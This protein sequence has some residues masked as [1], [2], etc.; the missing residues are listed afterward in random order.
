MQIFEYEGKRIT[1]DFGD[2][3]EMVSATE[4][5]KAFEEKRLRDFA[6]LKQTKEFIKELEYSMNTAKGENPRLWK[7]ATRSVRGGNNPNLRGIWY[8]KRLALKLAAWLN[9]KFEVWI[10]TQ[11]SEETKPEV[12]LKTLEFIFQKY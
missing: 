1:F 3:E 10:F 11:K 12:E 6:A 8:E 5:I 7:K 9:P 4:I 2:G